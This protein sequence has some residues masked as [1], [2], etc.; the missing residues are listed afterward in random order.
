M[1]KAKRVVPM[2][3]FVL[4]IGMLPALANGTTVTNNYDE[5]DGIIAHNKI[6]HSSQ[7]PSRIV[8]PVKNLE[9]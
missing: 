9:N 4:F 5:K 3:V 6:H 1:M 2:I 7:Y 8:L